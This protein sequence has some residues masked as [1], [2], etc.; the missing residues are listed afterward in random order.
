MKITNVHLLSVHCV[1]IIRLGSW[2]I[3]YLNDDVIFKKRAVRRS[4]V[5]D[6]AALQSLDVFSSSDQPHEQIN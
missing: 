2:Y 3:K 4:F 5:Y 1:Y 6:N